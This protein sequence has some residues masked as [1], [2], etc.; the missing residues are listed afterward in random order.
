[1]DPWDVLSKAKKGQQLSAPAAPAPAAA[2]PEA[3]AGVDAAEIAA[4]RKEAR[5]QLFCACS[6]GNVARVA[7]ILE[8]GLVGVNDVVHNLSKA[9]PIHAAVRHPAV[10]RALLNLGARVDARRGDGSTALCDAAD[11]G[12]PVE[13]VKLL[14]DEFG[15]DVNA[16]DDDGN[17]PLDLAVAADHRTVGDIIEGRGG[18]RGVKT[19]PVDIDCDPR[20]TARAAAVDASALLAD[21]SAPARA[22]AAA[23]GAR[24]CQRCAGPA[25]TRCSRC[26][27]TW[28]CGPS[29]QKASWA[30]HRD[31]CRRAP[32]TKKA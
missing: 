22:P 18:L 12:L 1:M 14:M 28:Y 27:K 26:Q 9:R 31:I 15:A 11:N 20:P 10:L 8:G 23:V 6:D 3:A 25:K 16:C 30:S 4:K 2:A 29:C 13:S 7:E 21:A 5:L 32:R 24:V 17:T 19:H